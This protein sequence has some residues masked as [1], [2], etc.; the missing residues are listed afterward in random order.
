MSKH[1]PGPWSQGFTLLTETTKRWTATQVAENDRKERRMVFS[2][3][4]PEDQG[5]GRRLVAVFEREED[6]V[7]G[8]AAPRLL[9]ALKGMLESGGRNERDEAIA[10]LEELGE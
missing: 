4:T 9:H 6:A 3:F 1:T 7:L 2:S 8:A 10:L 5:R